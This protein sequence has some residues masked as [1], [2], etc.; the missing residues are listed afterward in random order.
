MKDSNRFLKYFLYISLIIIGLIVGVA[1]RHYYNIPIAETINMVD[2]GT[3]VVTIFL[4]VYIP[5]VLDRKLQIKRDK[6]DLIEK[7]IEELQALYRRMNLVVQSEQILKPKDFRVIKNT[8]D[9]TQHKLETIITLLTYSNMHTSFTED[10]KNIRKLCKEH[11]DLLWSEDMEDE[12]FCYAEDIQEK[13]EL[14]YNKID[15][16]T[17]LLIFK[18]SEA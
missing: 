6:K 9:I 5:E 10:I 17:C 14:L 16:T 1:V 2:L 8:S 3:L 4:A 11:Q 15:E 7:R 18:I 13:E 12:G